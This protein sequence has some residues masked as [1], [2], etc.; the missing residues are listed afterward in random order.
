MNFF[1]LI[2]VLGFAILG[3]VNGILILTIAGWLSDSMIV[4]EI[5][6]LVANPKFKDPYGLD[7]ED[8]L[9]AIKYFIIFGWTV[10]IASIFGFLGMFILICRLTS[11]D[12]GYSSGYFSLTK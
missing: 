11:E 5:R 2:L 10:L 9:K 7:L 4:K 12:P 8:L 1:Q 3:I 6:Q